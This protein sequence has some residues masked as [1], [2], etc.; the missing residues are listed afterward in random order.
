MLAL[1]RIVRATGEGV[2]GLPPDQIYDTVVVDQ[3]RFSSVDSIAGTQLRQ[4][5]ASML[6]HFPGT[7]MEEC[8]IARLLN[9][10]SAIK[11]PVLICDAVEGSTNTR[12]GLASRIGRPIFGGTSIM[13]LENNLMASVIASAFYDF[14]SRRV[15][16]SVRGEPG[17]FF[18]FVD[19]GLISWE[20]VIEARGDSQ[21]YA[22][23]A[24]YSHN[25]ILCRT[26]VEGSL[27]KHG[28]RAT[29]GTRSSA[30]DLLDIVCNQVDAYVD[31]RA[32]FPGSTDSQDEVL[33][34]WDVGG[35]LPVLDGLGFVIVD[36]AN[37]SWQDYKLGERFPLVVSRP[38]IAGA[39][40]AAI[41]ELPFIAEPAGEAPT[42]RFQQGG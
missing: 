9:D 22:V 34:I 21:P 13:V 3:H 14:A 4:H 25:N 11:Y 36:H 8:D 1:C 24:G 15:F 30:Q 27:L 12:R 5:V 38:S 28:I 31:L 16:S 42:V 10:A 26:H 6:P 19:G 33:H 37:R 39:I 35:L 2:L 23:V 29:G 7:L 41:S 40:R 17:S 20:E 18:P 32:L